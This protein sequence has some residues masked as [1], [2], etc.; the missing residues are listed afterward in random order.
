MDPNDRPDP[1]PSDT[2]EQAAA[3]REIFEEALSD[4]GRAPG[5]RPAPLP[6]ELQPHFADLVIE[7]LIGE[8]GMGYVYRAR[9]RR[10]DRQVALKVMPPE[11]AADP[12]FAERFAREARTLA[13]LDHPH[14]VRVHDFG[15][16]GGLYWL[17]MELVEGA[18]LRQVMAA[19]SLSPEEALAIVPQ[20]C[21]ALGFAHEN[22]IV[23]RDIKPENILLDGRGQVKITDFGLAKLAARRPGEFTLTGTGQVM[24][25][26][27][28]MAPE[29][30]KSPEEVDHRADIFSLGVVFYEMLTGE[31]P[32]GR[33]KAP[34]ESKRLD[35]RIDHI[36]LKALEREREMRYQRANEIRTDIGVLSQPPAAGVASAAPVA[37]A[38]PRHVPAPAAPPAPS[39]T[40]TQTQ[41]PSSGGL[42]SLISLFVLPG[43]AFAV[44]ALVHIAYGGVQRGT[45]QVWER[46]LGS[47]IPAFLIC[48]LGVVL[49]L[50]LVGRAKRANRQVRRGFGITAGWFCG[51]MAAFFIL[52]TGVNVWLHRKSDARDRPSRGAVELRVGSQEA[53]SGR[54]YELSLLETWSQAAHTL[55]NKTVDARE[56][57]NPRRVERVSAL[58]ERGVPGLRERLRMA[59]SSLD[60]F[61]ESLGLGAVPIELLPGDPHQYV[62]T[63]MRFR[64]DEPSFVGTDAE[65]QVTSPDGR[66]RIDFP[67]RL[68]AGGKVYL[69]TGKTR[70]RALTPQ[71]MRTMHWTYGSGYDAFYMDMKT[72]DDTPVRVWFDRDSMRGENLQTYVNQVYNLWLAGRTLLRD[73]AADF[74]DALPYY[75]PASARQLEG[76]GEG[77]IGNARRTGDLGLPL[78]DPAR[79]PASLREFEISNIHFE[80]RAHAATIVLRR[81]QAPFDMRLQIRAVRTVG[82]GE[83][84]QGRGDRVEPAF[85][86]GFAAEPV[87]I[88]RVGDARAVGDG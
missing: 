53:R 66:T 57:E 13:G 20:V 87:S 4:T 35:A 78:W 82:A 15:E 10:L 37:P 28:Y 56:T 31:L 65:V 59:L 5:R 84:F 22:G 21:D 44:Y 19:G 27:H 62:V 69:T 36:V 25:T 46:E 73:G 50:V 63:R 26:V 54:G 64:S 76:T 72:H 6:S 77:K 2:P 71:G 17:L 1:S 47:G 7:E 14:I 49:S 38:A 9:Q 39:S 32:M 43:I 68:A 33:F 24:G 45:D 40:Q 41:A 18:N 55:W 29:Q 80:G 8:G 86:W 61:D 48:A 11:L 34:S 75:D 51:A 83:A 81:N 60:A 85:D 52:A 58:Y 16:S 88:E 70:R 74:D 30:Y 79:M 23:H 3:A 12:S 42:A 67:V